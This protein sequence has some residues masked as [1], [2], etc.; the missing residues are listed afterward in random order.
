MSPDN[1]GSTVAILVNF[2]QIFKVSK[3]SPFRVH[4][5]AIAKNGVSWPVTSRAINVLLLRRTYVNMRQCHSK[6]LQNARK[7]C[8][9]RDSQ[10]SILRREQFSSFNT[11]IPMT[12]A[13]KREK[14]ESSV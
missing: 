11:Y 13:Q 9:W 7:M 2:L 12:L 5:R 6:S 1:R 4:D 8:F 10:Y 14:A 3:I